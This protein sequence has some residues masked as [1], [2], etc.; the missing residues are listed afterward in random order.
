MQANTALWQRKVPLWATIA[1]TLPVLICACLVGAF[2][3]APSQVEQAGMVADALTSTALARPTPTNLATIVVSL[4]P[5]TTAMPN[6]SPTPSS[7]PTITFTPSKTSAPT[8][9]FTATRTPDVRSLY[10][11]VDIRE[12]DA[13]PDDHVGENVKLEGEVFNIGDDFFQ[14]SVRKPGGSSYDT[15]PVIVTYF[16]ITRPPGIYEDSNVTTYGVVM[17]TQE[18]TNAFGGAISQLWID[19]AIIEKK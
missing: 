9:T 10:S 15:I 14:L 11:A 4:T 13:Y 3:G 17:G 16:T 6:V 2:F 7:T 19:A 1:V 8:R 12:L 18:G 5:S